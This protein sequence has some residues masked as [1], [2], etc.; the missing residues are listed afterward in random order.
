MIS[1]QDG[2]RLFELS[3]NQSLNALLRFNETEK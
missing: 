3:D 1:K 2:D